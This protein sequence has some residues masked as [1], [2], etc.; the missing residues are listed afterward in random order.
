M[1]ALD[2][3]SPLWEGQDQVGCIPRPHPHATSQSEYRELWV[4]HPR[5]S[6]LCL[7]GLQAAGPEYP[8]GPARP[9]TPTCYQKH[10]VEALGHTEGLLPRACA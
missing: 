9:R 1:G 10:G 8:W 7:G 5:P 6:I 3:L 4:L 2:E